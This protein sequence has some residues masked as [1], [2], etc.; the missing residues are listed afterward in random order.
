M[1]LEAIEMS[2]VIP[3]QPHEI[4]EAWLDGNEHAAL[5]GSPATGDPTVG[6]RFTA[7]DGY[8]EGRNLELLPPERIVQSWRTGDFPPGSQDSRLVITL[9][10]DPGG[11]LL[12]LSHSD[13][14]E[15]SSEEYAQGWRDYYFTPMRAYYAANRKV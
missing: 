8:I 6:G 10:P 2:E 5:T 7:W 12:E 1:A 9:T 13:L 3:A 11:T 15:G 14:P 4:Y